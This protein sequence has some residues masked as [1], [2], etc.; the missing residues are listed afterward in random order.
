MSVFWGFA[1]LLT[2][3][4][5][6]ATPLASETTGSSTSRLPVA[7]N[8]SDGGVSKSSNSGKA[9]ASDEATSWLL[10]KRI[11]S[12]KAKLADVRKALSIANTGALVNTI[13]AL[14]IMRWHRGVQNL[15]LA[16]WR[17][18][19]ADRKNYPDLAWVK[20]EQPV[21]RIA[22]ASTLNRLNPVNRE[23]IRYIRSRAD[24]E[25]E[26]H[27]AQVAVALG[28]NHDPADVEYLVKLANGDNVYVV[29][30]AITALALM[31][32]EKARMALVELEKKYVR[33]PRGRLAG[34]VL[35]RAYPTPKSKK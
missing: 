7:S 22:I 9:K 32:E 24:D 19:D 6:T 1:I 26:F 13:H 10:Y 14:Y 8:S 5:V 21:T 2:C 17:H 33:D 35:R 28:L 18:S 12:G 34:E 20:I 11:V 25:H 29:Q 31:D 15:L 3:L 4:L 23:Y 30:S 27:K 16:M